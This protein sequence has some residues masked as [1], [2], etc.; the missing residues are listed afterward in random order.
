M[1]VSHIIKVDPQGFG[2]KKSQGDKYWEKSDI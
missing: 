2:E 1:Y